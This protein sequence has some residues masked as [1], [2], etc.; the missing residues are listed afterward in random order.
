MT[1]ATPA[2]A[3]DCCDEWC[4]EGVEHGLDVGL[5]V[6]EVFEGDQELVDVA[7]PGVGAGFV[8]A[9]VEVGFDGFQCR[10]LQYSCRMR[11]GVRGGYPY[12]RCRAELSRHRPTP[13][14]H[15]R[16]ARWVVVRPRGAR[17]PSPRPTAPEL[18]GDPPAG[19]HPRC[20]L[21]R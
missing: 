13:I 9:S 14:I 10:V 15:I 2:A 20:P 8:D 4:G 7:E 21:R 11:S 16:H 18:Q 19:H 17:S 5:L 12:F 6:F 3:F 1:T